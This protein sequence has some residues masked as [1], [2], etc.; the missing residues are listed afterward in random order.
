MKN[1]K[2]DIESR[3]EIKASRSHRT[4]L[5]FYVVVSKKIRL[6]LWMCIRLWK[7]EKCK[8]IQNANNIRK[9]IKYINYLL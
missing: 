5:D 6:I 3:A 9:S 8:N 7:V 4:K 1:A 2:S